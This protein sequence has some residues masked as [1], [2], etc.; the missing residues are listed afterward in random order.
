MRRI[1]GHWTA[2]GHTPSAL[3]LSHYHFVIDGNGVVH[4]GRFAPEAN[5]RP[6]TGKY[7][8]HTRRCN[9]GSIGVAIAAMAG[10]QERPFRW[11]ASPITA[12]QVSAYARLCADLAK[13]YNIAVTR[14]TTLTHAEVQPT[15][16]IAQRGKWDITILPGMDAPAN[17]V[18][19]GDMLRARIREFMQ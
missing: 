12:V 8:A 15:L 10:A 2:G 14:E 17:P 1:I 16:K 18:A 13:Q 3:D 6:V 5:L 19:V 9:T 11:G 4:R 7:A